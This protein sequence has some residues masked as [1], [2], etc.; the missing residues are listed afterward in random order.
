MMRQ[1]Q[2]IELRRGFG[3]L[4]NGSLSPYHAV[5]GVDFSSQADRFASVGMVVANDAQRIGAA[6]RTPLPAVVMPDG[7]GRAVNHLSGPA[8]NAAV[9]GWKVSSLKGV[10]NAS[11]VS[12]A[13]FFG[14]LLVYAGLDF[15]GAR[16]I[17]KTVQDVIRQ[18]EPTARVV[19]VA[20]GGMALAWAYSNKGPSTEAS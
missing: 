13:M 2:K 12:V 7:L 18:P 4:P 17:R 8:Q 20:V 6:T 14:G 9:R 15:P 1:N 10:S 3:A 16:T 5:G 11:K 19:S